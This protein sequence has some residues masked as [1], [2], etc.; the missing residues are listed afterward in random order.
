MHISV[1]EMISARCRTIDTVHSIGVRAHTNSSRYAIPFS[2]IGCG[3]NW[4][5]PTPF[6]SVLHVCSC[7]SC[8]TSNRKPCRLSNRL[9]RHQLLCVTP[10][11]GYIFLYE[12]NSHASRN[13][14]IRSVCIIIFNRIEWLRNQCV[15]VG[16]IRI[17]E[18][19]SFFCCERVCFSDT[20]HLGCV[21][22]GFYAFCV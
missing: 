16:R 20:E 22:G 9:I 4:A 1:H 8:R 11:H 19:I 21:S 6:E 18:S 17:F 7:H 12:R 15:G 10:Q 5:L 2:G 3:S 13:P 14:F